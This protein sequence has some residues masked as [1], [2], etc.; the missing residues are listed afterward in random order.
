LA[1]TANGAKNN[2]QDQMLTGLDFDGFELD[3]FNEY[4]GYLMNEIVNL[5]DE[6]TIS[7]ANSIWYDD[8]FNVL[9][10][11]LDVNESNYD[12][13]VSALDFTSPEAVN[14]I[15]N[16]VAENT[17]NKITEILDG[18]SQDAV[19]YLI[20]AVYFYGEWKYQFDKSATQDADFYL[21]D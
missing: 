19:M 16:W 5:D 17:N 4:F 6:V 9:Q 21:S 13:E 3:E 18:I 7:I 15:N 2:T 8:D 1:M 12:A 11:F 14:T 20:N 10:S